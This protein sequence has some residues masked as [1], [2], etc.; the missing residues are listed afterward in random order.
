MA[1][2]RDYVDTFRELSIKPLP[3]GVYR[4]A[5]TIKNP[6]PDKRT[7]NFYRR[8]TWHEG[9]IVVVKTDRAGRQEMWERNEYAH[10]GIR[11]GQEHYAARYEALAPHLVALPLTDPRTLFTGAYCAGEPHERNAYAILSK[12]LETGLIDTDMV[13]AAWRAVE[14]DTD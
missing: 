8:E 5:T 11:P 1:K 9:T 14:R 13:M 4:L 3:C 6:K 10:D 7:G 12:M 2:A